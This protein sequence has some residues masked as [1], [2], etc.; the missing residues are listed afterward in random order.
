MEE[1]R[2][3][4]VTAQSLLSVQG[5]TFG[6]HREAMVLRDVTAE[7]HAGRVTVLLG[8][9]ATGKS[10]LLKIMLGLENPWQ[11][12]VLLDGSDITRASPADR[13]ARVSFVPQHST[14]HASFSV[15]EVVSLGRFALPADRASVRWAIDA[16]D[17]RAISSSVY[18]ELSA[19]QQ[20]R[21]L[22]ARAIAQAGAASNSG[23][24]AHDLLGKAML[25]DEP[26]SAMDLRH[27]H[28][29]MRLLSQLAARG[30]AVLVVLHDLNLAAR[31]ADDVWLLDAGSL[32]A[33]GP[34]QNVM[35]E[36]TLAPVYRVGLSCQS[37]RDSDRPLF[38][39]I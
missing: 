24:V 7:L 20:Q 30:L 39:V 38:D 25:L 29:S 13:A 8:P 22:V 26:V 4:S 33:S 11:G 14:L 12:K 9:N 21:V 15:Q 16:M 31:Y 17:L 37:R 34:W 36:A 10:T 19:G 2:L 1:G 32:V 23:D 28:D 27:A 3:N 35:T 5:V 6:Y 18:A